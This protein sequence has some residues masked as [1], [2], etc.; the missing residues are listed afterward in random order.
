MKNKKNI[1]KIVFIALIVLILFSL[2]APAIFSQQSLKA[3]TQE[4]LLNGLRVLM[5]PEPAGED[6]QVKVRIHAGAAFD[7]QGKE[8]VMQLLADNIF[9]TEAQRDFFKEDLGGSL[10]VTTSHDFI[11]INASSKPDQMLTMLETIAA[12][13]ASIDINKETTVILKTAHLARLNKS[14]ASPVYVAD[15]TVAARLFGSFPYGRP[16]Y[17]TPASIAKLDFADLID[18]RTR[19]LTA[20]NATLSVSGKFDQALAYRAVRRYFG[21]WL[22][23]DKRVPTSFKQP[24]APNSTFLLV[25]NPAITAPEVRIAVRGLARNDTDYAASRAL[26][27]IIKSRLSM[28]E[29]ASVTRLEVAHDAHV[30]PGSFVISYTVSP[31][32]LEGKPATA[33]KTLADS[34]AKQIVADL[35]SNLTEQ[36]FARAKAETQMQFTTK[37]AADWYMDEDTFKVASAAKDYEVLQN[38]TLADVRRAATRLAKNPAVTIAVVK[39][40]GEAIK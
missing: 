19:F 30:Q 20:D 32:W 14:T 33:L 24:E 8:G 27:K 10:E 22:K 31:Q 4:K 5:W 2:V 15:Q 18:G 16:I 25:A 3:P 6:V 17:G 12:A 13:V 37:T 9:P 36:E 7:P 11:Q 28:A 35:T 39:P 23:S 26:A 29:S 38:L 40:S 21:A 1:Q 34:A